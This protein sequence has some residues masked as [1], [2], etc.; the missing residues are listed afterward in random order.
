M[1]MGKPGSK[2]ALIAAAFF[3]IST[4][5]AVQLHARQAR[6]QRGGRG[7]LPTP[8]EMKGKTAGEVYKNIKVLKN[9]PADRLIPGMRYITIA[10]GVRCNFCHNTKNF[11][12]DEKRPKKTARLMMSMLFSVNKNTFKGRPAIGCY[13]CH[14][15]RHSPVF[16]PMP[17]VEVAQPAAEPV[18]PMTLVAAKQIK[19]VPGT[20]LPA[21]D[22]VLAKYAD[23][24][25]GQAALGGVRTRE[26]VLER[27]QG[28]ANAPGTEEEIYEKAPDKFLIVTHN[29][30]NTFR[31]GF[32]GKQGWVATPRGPMPLETMDALTPMR[33]AQIDPAAAL[34]GYTRKRLRAMARIGGQTAYL[35]TA[36][37]PDGE[38]EQLYFDA[39]SGLL[40]RRVFIYR[41]IFGPLLYQADY[42][43]YQKE[44]DVLVPLHIEW[45][46]GGSGYTETVKS[47]K[48]NVPIS[49]AEFQPP[50]KPAGRGGAGRRQ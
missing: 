19:P 11:S 42:S 10:L 9:V 16:A 7:G 14:R 21:V 4:V 34:A 31:T 17:A 8:A 1:R 45:W 13:T 27:T 49:D 30:N 47:V 2:V 29:R 46:A 37:A 18:P 15:G 6:G 33:D 35:V 44:G 20:A 12:S 22:R 36:Q 50:P 24:L 26:L 43:D 25:G 32:N 28:N 3:L 23:A 38:N 48:T 41:T 39:K 5:A 40:L